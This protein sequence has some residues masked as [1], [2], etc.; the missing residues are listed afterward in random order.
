M[1]NKARLVKAARMQESLRIAKQEGRKMK[2]ATRVHNVCAISGRPRGYL[3]KFGVSRIV[4]RELISQGAIP[5]MRR[6]SW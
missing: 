4:L 5:G 1:V 2:F 6:S 3:R